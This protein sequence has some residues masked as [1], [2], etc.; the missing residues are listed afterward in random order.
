[1]PGTPA[2]HHIPELTQEQDL[3]AAPGAEQGRPGLTHNC[4]TEKI[5]A[6]VGCRH[7][8]R[9]RGLFLSRGRKTHAHLGTILFAVPGTPSQSLAGVSWKGELEVTVNVSAW[10]ALG[11]SC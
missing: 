11:K 2:D 10:A 8:H 6:E 5:Y 7:S 3:V 9:P 1:M 4:H